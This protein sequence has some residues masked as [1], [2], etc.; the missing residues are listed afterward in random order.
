MGAHQNSL[1]RPTFNRAVRVEAS[2]TPLTEDAGALL[3]RE[4]ADKLGLPRLVSTLLDHRVP[5]RVTHPLDELVLT[6]VLL[7][8]QGWQD[9]DDA[10]TLR[11][12]AAFRIAV[13]RRGSDRAL[14][15][16][17]RAREPEGLAS[18]PTHSRLTAM[19]ASEHNRRRLSQGL[20][21]LARERMRRAYG[22][23][24]RIIVDVD[25]YAHE[26]YG[27][28][29]G[30]AY[31]GHYRVEGY[32]PLAAFTDTGDIVGVM[33]RPGNVHTARDIR[34][35]LSPIIDRLKQDCDQLVIRMDAGYAAGKL[36]AWLAKRGVRFLTRLPNN[37]VLRK[38]VAD[39]EAKTLKS[40][41]ADP[42]EDGRAR[43]ATREFWHW[44]KGWTSVVRVVAVTVER[45]TKRGELFQHTFFLATNYA[46][47]QATSEAI[48]QAYRQRA[49]AETRIGELTRVIA[50]KLSCAQRHRNGAPH[51]KRKVGMAENEV[52]LLLAA[53]AYQLVHTLRCLLE[54][55]TGE[56]FS[57]DRLRER[58]LKVAASVVRHA[59][60]VHFRIASTKVELWR[61]LAGALSA[62]GADAG[63]AA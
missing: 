56:G 43:H 34:R 8:A 53:I 2:A 35:F 48:L 62:F 33:L 11:D 52:T 31:N 16:A 3:L 32:H 17:E 6:R 57:L 40:W 47:T 49:V 7:L 18:Q 51:R 44:V 10:D 25:S 13:S 42:T 59:R 15:P 23:R 50:P 29:D 1:F 28:Q 61:L 12:D 24:H 41:A 14:R 54:G 37:S 4:V 19:L 21:H 5:E 9:Q 22:R 38:R 58:V 46:R 30:T 36:L 63:V 20:L 60:A 55:A 45:D 27:N 26:T 39:W